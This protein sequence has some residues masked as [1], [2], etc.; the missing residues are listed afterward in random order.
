M[1]Y[2]VVL[3]YVVLLVCGWFSI[4]GA[5]HETGDTDFFAWEVR[6]GKQIVWIGCAFVLGFLVLMTDDKYFDMTA[7]LFYWL[8][9]LLLLV[10]PF[11]A[12]D[13]KGSRSW[14]NL[15][16]C[17]IQPAEFAKCVT[18]LA[19]A[20]L[21]N[22]YGF[23]MTDMRC[24]LRAAALILLPMV[25]IILQKET[26]SA[27]VYL[28]FFLM[29]YREGMPGCFLF[30]A[31]AAVVYFVVGIRFGETELPGTLSSVG[32]FTVLLPN[33]PT[34]FAHRTGCHGRLA[35]GFNAHHSL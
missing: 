24:F 3:L 10:T 2:L 13:I 33:C 9:M 20:K 22:R 25:L 19:V 5:T 32:E 23:T 4:C 21:L 16:F 26:G 8:M 28:A 7:D 17:N 34:L 29:F 18:A 31:V 6:T 27:L 35:V 14:V 11:I 12:K 30:T 15:G 1:D